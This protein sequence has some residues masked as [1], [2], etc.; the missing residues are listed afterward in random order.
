MPVEQIHQNLGTGPTVKITL[1]FFK[2]SDDSDDADDC[3]LPEKGRNELVIATLQMFPGETADD[4]N[5]S[6]A[7]ANGKTLNAL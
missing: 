1:R 4:E 6:H 5:E 7:A 3:G 2:D